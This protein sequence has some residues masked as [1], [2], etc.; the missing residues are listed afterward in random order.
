MTA[1]RPSLQRQ[2]TIIRPSIVRPV[3]K[4]PMKKNAPKSV[5]TQYGASDMMRSNAI[6]VRAYAYTTI[7]AGASTSSHRR[8]RS[9]C[10]GAGM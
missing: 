8:L 9:R 4:A 7:S 2:Y 10:S 5:L 6:T 1:W 3:R